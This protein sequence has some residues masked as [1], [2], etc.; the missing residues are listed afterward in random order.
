MEQMGLGNVDIS[1]GHLREC[2]FSAD[3]AA[4]GEPTLPEMESG[5]IHLAIPYA[6]VKLPIFSVHH[7]E[8]W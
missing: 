4:I 7:R 8:R 6:V 2:W 1:L 5:S 3:L